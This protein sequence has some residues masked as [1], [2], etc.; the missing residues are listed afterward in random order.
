MGSPT[1]KRQ[2]AARIRWGGES[3]MPN[4]NSKAKMKAPKGKLSHGN[5]AKASPK[6]RGKKMGK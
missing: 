2:S 4:Q 5:P 1:F 3:T 6:P